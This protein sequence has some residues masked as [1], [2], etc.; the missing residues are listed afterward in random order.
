M[1]SLN[2]IGDVQ[3]F[4]ELH[5][6]AT[7]T[8]YKGYQTSLERTVLVKVLNP[9]LALDPNL[10]SSFQQEAKLAAKIQHPN[11]MTLYSFG[12]ADGL[13]YFTAEFVDGC[14]LRT[15]LEQHGTLPPELACL[16]IRETAQ[17]LQAA[18]KAGILHRDIKP[19]NILISQEGSV[20]L[21]DFGLA[22]LHN[23]PDANSDETVGT[24]AYLS[25]EEIL[26]GDVSLASDL[27]ALGAT[28]YELL[29]GVQAF[30]AADINHCFKN[31]LEKDP[32]PYLNRQTAI[33][34]EL[35]NVCAKMLEKKDSRRYS[36]CKQLLDAMARAQKR[37]G[38]RASADDLMQFVQAPE[39]YTLR[40]WSDSEEA[41]SDSVSPG[42][43]VNTQ[44][45]EAAFTQDKPAGRRYLSAAVGLA[46]VTIAITWFGWR[47]IFVQNSP[48]K[49]VE[50]SE[51]V[52]SATPV[53]DTV[54][55]GQA[56]SEK[57]ASNGE[58]VEL[59]A[60]TNPNSKSDPRDEMRPSVKQKTKRILP[61]HG[62]LHIACTPWAAVYMNGDSIGVTPI[63]DSL[64][65]PVG[66]HLVLLRNAQFPDF[67]TT[68]Q[69]KPG[70]QER[71][72]IS[73]WSTVGKLN[74]NI[75]PWAEVFVD[76][77]YKD[78]VPPQRQPIVVAPGK[79]EL[80]LKHPALGEWRTEFDIAAQQQ[81]NLEFN[82]RNLLGN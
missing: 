13:A 61:D 2:Q 74:L 15:L 28:F 5:R 64:K 63:A 30:A 25:P 6:G 80:L 35:S 59:P 45:S 12:V 37:H 34:A 77:S 33:P 54:A 18:H 81:L 75:S 14:N 19:E 58:D 62:Y 40:E 24:F 47:Q 76:G 67:S 52:L 49:T 16:I 42:A 79:H 51:P 7:A 41:I 38:L 57:P 39:T 36:N 10:T 23:K 60:S 27:F 44:K 3:I 9:E 55:G 20:K 29:S 4:A 53:T 21:G 22:G 48:I 11:V 8:V 82:L 46:A 78:T 1:A 17:G 68:V 73:L 72:D 31:I 32:L 66:E 69:I 70:R 26:G 71:L 56:L 65:L 50:R 43:P